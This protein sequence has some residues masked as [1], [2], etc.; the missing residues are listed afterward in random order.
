MK[1]KFK[2]EVDCANCAAKIEEAIRKIPGVREATVS[3]MTQKF[4]LEA[5]DE[6]FESILS[7]AQKI[8]KKVDSDSVIII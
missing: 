2:I 6:K 1:K 3:F 5:D 4:T 8:C 7:E